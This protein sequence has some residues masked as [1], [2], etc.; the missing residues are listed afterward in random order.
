MK[1]F[2]AILI[3]GGG[4]KQDGGLPIWVER[5]FNKLL[6]IYQGED[7]ITLSA[8]TTY[9]PP[10]LDKDGFPIFE[11]VAGALYLLERGIPSS[12][13][14]VEKCSYDTIGNA[15]FGKII[16][17]D[18]RGFSN[19]LIITSEFHIERTKAVFKWVFGLVPKMR[20][21]HLTFESVSD[22]GIDENIILARRIA[23]KRNLEKMTI[24]RKR[25]TNTYDFHRWIFTEHNAYSMDRSNESR[26]IN[27]EL[28]KSY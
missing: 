17:V 23:E 14:L 2:D 1:N 18:P 13:I 16:H 19:L 24:L 4:L 8:G 7:I 11:S 25:I 21:Y 20:N 15:F 26:Q 3:P 10:P 27:S 12:K 5:R 22:I 28:L 9:K 6:E